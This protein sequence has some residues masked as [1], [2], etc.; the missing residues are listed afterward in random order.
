MPD[1]V[2]IGDGKAVV[3]KVESHN[4]QISKLMPMTGAATGVRW[5]NFVADVLANGRKSHSC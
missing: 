4:H 1:V 3:F 5:Q 2:D